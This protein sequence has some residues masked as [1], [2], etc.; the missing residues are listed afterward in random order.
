MSI[1][2]NTDFKLYYHTIKHLK[3]IQ[4]RYRLWYM[5]R[6][7]LRRFTGHSYP[8]SIPQKGH[9]LSLQAGIPKPSTFDFRASTSTKNFTFLNQSYTFKEAIDWNFSKYGKLWAYNLNYFDYL[10][11][12]DIT[13][14]QGL[15][16]IYEFIDQI[17]TNS[18]GLEPYP[19]S[20][21]GMSWIKF[22]SQYNIQ[23][24]VID[25]SLYAQYQILL[26]NIEY[27]VLGNHLL[28]N[29]CSLLFGASYFRKKQM[30]EE[31]QTI[32][33]EELEE[34]ILPDGGHYERSV[35]Y[36]SIILE[37]LLDCCNVLMNNAQLGGQDRLEEVI[38]RKI[39]SMLSWLKVV[40]WRN[41]TVPPVNDHVPEMLP[42]VTA[43][44][45]Y[46][47]RLNIFPKYRPL[48]ESGYRKYQTEK[49]EVLVDIG[50]IGPDYIPGHAH[51]DIFSFLLYIGEKEIITD[52][53][54][55]TYENNQQRQTERSTTA[56][57]TVMVDGKEQNEVWSAFRVGRRGHVKILTDKEN[58]IKAE[59]D[60]Y[61]FMGVM[62]ERQ[63]KFDTDE[64]IIRDCLKREETRN[65]GVFYLHFAPGIEVQQ[66]V[67]GIEGN[68][69][70]ISFT[71]H[72]S[73]HLDQYKK[74]TGYAKYK[75]A[76]QVN[77]GFR[78]ELIT[79]IKIL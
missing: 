24:P 8:L 75:E 31:A 68:G 11:Q 5:L 22:L 35:M 61:Q 69:F 23:N 21:R 42:D 46:A 77:I 30:W 37:R 72:S 10:L 71:G 67:D 52:T 29:G 43:L 49:Y 27:Q 32:L 4:I 47:E 14:E 34:Q 64:L 63:F 2:N 33:L 79:Q 26:G 58:K 55:S 70:K 48:K 76:V 6:D 40:Q 17:E 74:A 36:H 20:L 3:P 59:H 60:G 39:K 28:E 15:E 78:D 19:I 7:K 53:G 45:N 57:N 1:N 50:N 13:K 54:T 51:S 62:H 9:S 41:G 25:A 65:P 12:E 73:I 38:S 44:V 16:L 18:E 56:H 66:A